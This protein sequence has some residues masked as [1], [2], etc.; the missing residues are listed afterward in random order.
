MFA[1]PKTSRPSRLQ[2]AFAAVLAI[3]AANFLV[4]CRPKTPVHA[5]SLLATVQFEP[6]PPTTHGPVKLSVSLSDAAGKPLQIDQLEVEGD[7]NHAGMTPVFAHL[8][9]T[10][11]GEF[12]GEIQFTMGGDWF[13][14]LTAQLPGNTH[15]IK[16]IDVPGVKA[17]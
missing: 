11:P 10:G 6:N 7:M 17:Q 1:S 15:F 8:H 12:A 16:K 5:G 13:I 3:F 14:L 4:G 9:K 2:L